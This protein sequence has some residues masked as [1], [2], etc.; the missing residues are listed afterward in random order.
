MD[1]NN[2]DNNENSDSPMNSN[3]D[4]RGD[5]SFNDETETRTAGDILDDFCLKLNDINTT[6]PDS[7][8]NHYMKKAGF[9]VNDTKLVKIVSIASQKFISEI[10]NDVMQH[11]K[12]KTKSSHNSTANVVAGSAGPSSS[13]GTATS[14][15]PNTAS[16]NIKST[17]TNAPPQL[18]LTLEDL[19]QVLLDY[20]INVK[21]PYYFM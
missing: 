16:K 6:L 1:Y 11:H 17:S 15:A 12:M 4:A 2:T 18:T 13:N 5:G 19:S 3:D 20:G 21:K 14:T 7:V 9:V 10:V 8:V